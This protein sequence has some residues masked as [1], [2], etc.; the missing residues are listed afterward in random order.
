MFKYKFIITA[1][2]AHAHQVSSLDKKS[3]NIEMELQIGHVGNG[4][5]VMASIEMQ[6]QISNL[7]DS[8]CWRCSSLRWE[9]KGW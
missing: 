6:M 7:E 8:Q 9:M 5:S 3:T 2:T 1:D 4:I